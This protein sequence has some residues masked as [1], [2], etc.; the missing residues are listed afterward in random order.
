MTRIGTTIIWEK[1]LL[2]NVRIVQSDEIRAM[3][4]D[5]GKDYARSLRYLLEHRYLMRI[6]RGI[7]YVLDQEEREG[8]SNKRTIYELVSEALAIK[9][10]RH[11]YLAL[12]TALKLNGLTHEYFTVN[13]VITDNYRTTKVIGIGDLRFRFSRWRGEMFSFGLKRE[14]DLIFSDKE[15]T[16]LDMVHRNY[17]HS[18]DRKY[19]VAPLREYSRELDKKKVREYLAH[20]NAR[21]REIVEEEL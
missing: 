11:W 3:A 8:G 18:K 21:V 19:S 1:L 20:Y 12:E 16:I 9:G 14:F 2:N 13:Y 17:L 15:K 10:A 5:I 6:L 7:F 4:Q